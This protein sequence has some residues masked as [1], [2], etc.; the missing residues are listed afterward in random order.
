MKRIILIGCGKD[1]RTVATQAQDIY[2]GQTFKMRKRYALDQ[3]RLGLAD[4]WAILSAKLGLVLPTAIIEP[5][6]VSLYDMGQIELDKWHESTAQQ[7]AD[8]FGVDHDPPIKM[9][10]HCADRY[11]ALHSYLPITHEI[12]LPVAGLSQGFHKKYYSDYFKN[13]KPQTTLNFL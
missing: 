5:Y 2:V 12:D 1:K 10:F 6:D 13:Q 9:S 3:I 8:E 7:I 4:E 11:S